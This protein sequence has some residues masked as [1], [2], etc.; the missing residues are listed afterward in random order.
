MLQEAMGVGIPIITTDVPGPSEV[1]ENNI[2]GIL[3]KVKDHNDLAEK[4]ILLYETPA[5]RDSFSKAGLERAEKYFDRPIMLD[6][7]LRDMDKICKQG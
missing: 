4:M 2:S 7:L 6:N 1:I 3:C 5:L